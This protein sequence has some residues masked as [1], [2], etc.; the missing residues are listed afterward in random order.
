MADALVLEDWSSPMWRLDN[1]YWVLDDKG[2]EVPFRLRR[3]Q[4]E[5]LENLHN[6]NLV[7]KSRQIGFTTVISLLQLDQCIFNKGYKAVTIADTLQSATEI[8]R[9]KI[10]FPWLKLPED[11]RKAMPVVTDSKTEYVWATGSSIGTT[12]S[13]RG[14]TLQSLHV[15]EYGK[16]CAKFPDKAIE[17]VT[18]SFPAVVLDGGMI[19]VESTAKGQTGKFYEMAMGALRRQQSG[20][21]LTQLDFRMHFYPWWRKHTNRLSIDG[22]HLSQANVEYFLRLEKEHA[23]VLD[24]EQKSWYVKTEETLGDDMKA[25]H[26]SFPEEAFEV[27]IAGAIFSKEMA[28]LRRNGSIGSFPWEP[29]KRVNTFWDLGVGKGNATAIWCHQ[30]IQGRNRLI[31]YIEGEGEGLGYFVNKLNQL[32]YVWGPD[33]LPHDAEQRKAAIEIHSA[34]SI[35]ANLGRPQ[36]VVVPKVPHKNIAIEALRSFL[37][38]CEIDARGCVD[39]IRALDAYQ[40]EWDDKLGRWSDNPLHNWASNG[41]D[42]LM[43]GAQGYEPDTEWAQVDYEDEPL[44]RLVGY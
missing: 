19:F 38:T 6:W 31:H 33:Y 34:K 37:M 10:E 13:A 36:Q 22:V 5:F 30:R 11:L 27:A 12:T 3:E 4:R 41:A 20:V 43:Q 15:S 28:F 18:G 16:I 23:I 9:T 1:L 7:L 24:P 2:R 14:G 35:L 26:P 29:R 42:A 32:G 40:R 17:I 21:P 44:D 25:E 8:F 39:G